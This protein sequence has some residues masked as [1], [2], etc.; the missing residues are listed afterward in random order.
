MSASEEPR[1]RRRILLIGWDAADWQH[2]DPL[3][4]RGLMP[5]LAGLLAR[6]VRGN[7]AS[8][9]PMVSP[10][11]WTSVVT[12]RTADEHGVH[13]FVEADP[14]GKGVRPWSSLSRR[15]KA[16]WNILHQEGWRCST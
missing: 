5:S 6:G 13:G 7:L 11:L 12:G 8:L 4:E 14:S 15:G 1:K 2:I 3:L 16:V 9:M 10:M